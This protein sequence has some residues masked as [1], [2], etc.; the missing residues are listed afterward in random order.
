MSD[1]TQIR[2]LSQRILETPGFFEL[3]QRMLNDEAVAIALQPR[4]EFIASI[5]E[6]QDTRASILKFFEEARLDEFP[7]DL[8]EDADEYRVQAD[9]YSLT[10]KILPPSSSNPPQANILLITVESEDLGELEVV[11]DMVLETDLTNQFRD[12]MLVW[13]VNGVLRSWL[14]YISLHLLENQ[15]RKLVIS[16][17]MG[18]EDA[19]WWDRRI[20]TLSGGTFAVYKRREQ[21]AD[22]V[23]HYPDEV[24]PDIFF[25]DLSALKKIISDGVN[26]NDAFQR[27]F[28]TRKYIQRMGFLNRLRRK[29]AHN[30]FLTERNHKDL[31]DLLSE[32]LRAFRRVWGN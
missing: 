22:D 2:I 8:N 18:I 5:P 20:Q 15:L 14:S 9:T 17:L 12:F 31:S 28:L 6:G 4:V 23:T 11:R 3:V 32:F 25:T 7:L 24:A 19:R 16:R 1:E 13:D 26:W 10:V 29:I 30:R 27:V 21:G